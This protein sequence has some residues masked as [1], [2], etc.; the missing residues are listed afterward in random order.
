VNLKLDILFQNTENIVCSKSKKPSSM[1]RTKVYS[2]VPPYF[3]QTP[4]LWTVTGR[5]A[6]CYSIRSRSSEATFD[7]TIPGKPFSLWVFLS[8]WRL[9]LTPLLHCCIFD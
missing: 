2:A 1:K 8:K 9:L 3:R 6:C 5:P 7:S 4:A